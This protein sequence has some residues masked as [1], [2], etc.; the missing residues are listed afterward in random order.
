[1]EDRRKYILTLWPGSE[2]FD[3]GV[4]DPYADY[5]V[6]DSVTR[7]DSSIS[8]GSATEKGG[9]WT[10]LVGTLGVESD[11]LY[12]PSAT[13]GDLASLGSTAN[14]SVQSG[15]TPGAFGTTGLFCRGSDASNYLLVQVNVIGTVSMYSYVAGSATLLTIGG[16]VT[17][18]PLA[19]LR[20]VFN[21]TSV[22]ASVDGVDIFGV[23]TLTGT[24]AA[25]SGTDCGI[26]SR[27]TAS[28][29]NRWKNFRVTL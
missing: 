18:G 12:F 8:G 27:G 9:A 15:V 16:P 19:V 10:A 1:M 14:G 13:E 21:G 4:V 3:T 25:L 20:I 6:F 7:A 29:A 23:F 5:I 26:S 28:G 17:L 24:A 11:L 2:L 22:S